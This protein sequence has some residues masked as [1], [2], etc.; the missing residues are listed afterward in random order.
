M[1]N[2]NNKDTRTNVLQETFA[3]WKFWHA[4]LL[5]TSVLRVALLRYYRGLAERA[6][7]YQ[8]LKVVKAWSVTVWNIMMQNYQTFVI[9]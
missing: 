9:E 8:E 1:F 2:V 6:S 5:E 3:F 4:L 7:I